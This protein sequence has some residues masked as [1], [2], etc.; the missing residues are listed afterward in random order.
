VTVFHTLTTDL[1]LE[2]PWPK[3]EDYVPEHVNDAIL[4]WG[5][6]SSVG[7]FAIQILHYYGY[8]NILA[9]ASRKHHEKLRSLGAQEIFDYND[10]KAVSSILRASDGKSI[11]FVLDCIGSQN[12]S[13]APIAKIAKKGTRVAILLPV[14]VRDSSDTQDPEYEMD[15]SKAADWSDGVEVRGVRTHFYPDVST[16]DMNFKDSR[17][18]IRRMISSSSIFSRISC[19]PC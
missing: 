2:T 16:L 8:K 1:G 15:V 13:I 17:L 6:S 18:T 14:I 5:G 19:I 7:Q 9:T 12:G 4:V 10:P 11:P 3:L